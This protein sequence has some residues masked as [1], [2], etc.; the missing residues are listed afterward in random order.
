MWSSCLHST[1]NVCISH[2]ILS[3]FRVF[4]VEIVES[5]KSISE[6]GECCSAKR[7]WTFGA[8]KGKG[9]SEHDPCSSSLAFLVRKASPL[10]SMEFQTRRGT[11]GNGPSWWFWCHWFNQTIALKKETEAERAAMSEPPFNPASN[12]TECLK[13][14]SV[15]WVWLMPHVL[16]HLPCQGSWLQEQMQMGR[17][18]TTYLGRFH[19]EEERLRFW[20]SVSPKLLRAVIHFY[21]S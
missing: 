15:W 21:Y 11:S 13:G 6:C 10:I 3:G 8:G 1:N 9:F 18:F 7:S 20:N 5:V 14:W 19:I 16:L 2:D 4:S 12:T 17:V